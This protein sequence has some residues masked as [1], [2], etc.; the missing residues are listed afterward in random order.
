MSTR[1]FFSGRAVSAV[2]AAAA[3]AMMSAGPVAAQST[4]PAAPQ[5]PA[6]KTAELPSAR[7][8]ID[9]HVAAIG[10]KDALMKNTSTHL[11]GTI[12]MPANG[13]SGP[14]EVFAAKPDKNVTKIT[15]GGIGEVLEG[16]DGTVAWTISPM[17]GP[18]IAQGKE[19]EQKKF[20]AHFLAELRDPSRYESI[21]TVAETTFDG[22][23]AYKVSLKRKGGGEDIEYYDVK[24]GLKSG[25]EITRDSPMGTVTATQIHTDYK[26][27]GHLLQPSTI[28][29]SMMGVE[30]IISVGSIDYDKVDPAVFELPAA[31]KALVK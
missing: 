22:R 6:A 31:I 20:D 1:S 18:M 9:R 5:A 17:T 7:S 19:L 4:A 28:K 3:V 25:G 23:P 2:A 10:G 8:I 15:L 29:Q 24:T 14:F 12:S 16:F 11:K 13:I 26:Q 27:F 21:T 30:Q